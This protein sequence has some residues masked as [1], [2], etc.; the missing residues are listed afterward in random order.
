[1]MPCS[2]RDFVAVY[3]QIEVYTVIDIV[4]SNSVKVE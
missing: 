4:S 2:L 1:M 3:S